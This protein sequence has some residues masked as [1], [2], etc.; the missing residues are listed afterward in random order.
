MPIDIDSNHSIMLK[1]QKLLWVGLVRKRFMRELKFESDLEGEVGR[2]HSMQG[3][4]DHQK[5][6]LAKE[7]YAVKHWK[8]SLS[9][10]VSEVGVGRD[11]WTLNYCPLWLTQSPVE[12]FTGHSHFCMSCKRG[13]DCTLFQTLHFQ[14][15]LIVIACPSGIKGRHVDS[16]L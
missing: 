2:K 9:L 3:T 1:N 15:G 11:K 12:M 7:Q 13:T 16:S 6:I 5:K 14:G 10:K 8:N 4:L